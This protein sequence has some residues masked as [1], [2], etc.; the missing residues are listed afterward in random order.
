MF[1]I[2]LITSVVAIKVDRWYRKRLLTKEFVRQLHLEYFGV[3]P[4]K[5]RIKRVTLRFGRKDQ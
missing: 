3:V 5:Y 1:L 4:E 2:A